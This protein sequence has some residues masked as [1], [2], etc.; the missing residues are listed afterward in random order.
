MSCKHWGG[1]SGRAHSDV[2]FSLWNRKSVCVLI[3]EKHHIQASVAASTHP[4]TTVMMMTSLTT[5]AMIAASLVSLTTPTPTSPIPTSVVCSAISNPYCRCTSPPSSSSSSPSPPPS[6]SSFPDIRCI[7]TPSPHPLTPLPQLFLREFCA[8]GHQEA[9]DVL[10]LKENRLKEVPEV[11]KDLRAVRVVDLSFNSLRSLSLEVLGGVGGVQVVDMSSNRLTTVSVE[12]ATQSGKLQDLREL[13]LARNSIESIN[14]SALS[15]L[16]GGGLTSLDLSHNRLAHVPPTTFTP[17]GMT[18]QSLDLSNNSLNN[19]HPLAF[20]PLLRLHTLSLAHSEI[21]AVLGRLGLPQHL[22]RLDLRQC[23]VTSV[24]RCRFSELRDLAVL[25]LRGNPLECTCQLYVLQQ[26]LQNPDS[27]QSRWTCLTQPPTAA[28]SSEPTPSSP[29]TTGSGVTGQTA[30]ADLGAQCQDVYTVCPSV[31][32]LLGNMVVTVDVEESGNTL[33]ISW[34][35]ETHDN[36]RIDGFQLRY[37]PEEGESITSDIVASDQR[38]LDI[39]TPGLSDHFMVCLDVLM[40][41]SAVVHQECRNVQGGSGNSMLVGIL[42]G[43][44]FLAPCIVIL[45]YVF[46][47]DSRMSKIPY[48]TIGNVEDVE[49]QNLAHGVVSVDGGDSKKA[50]LV[51][52]GS[53]NDADHAAQVVA[54][55]FVVVSEPGGGSTVQDP[56]TCSRNVSSAQNPST[57]HVRFAEPAKQRDCVE[58]ARSKGV[59]NLGFHSAEEKSPNPEHESTR[60]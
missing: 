9:V 43:V 40:Y 32:E 41:T 42:A 55:K 12:E 57:G 53:K 24:H 26:S 15:L 16:N 27:D 25:D 52:V 19:L 44:V 34:T 5:L 59:E 60:M 31:S 28:N 33:V 3:G 46:F 49:K 22:T 48:Y 17:L 29:T 11:L 58:T 23:G 51:S 18:L 56:E 8:A 30:V 14:S 13:R 7:F 45:A 36:L 35:L 37:M 54:A 6:P 4:P 38:G 2:V 20:R 1:H 47:K 21:R 39:D 50:K 10:I